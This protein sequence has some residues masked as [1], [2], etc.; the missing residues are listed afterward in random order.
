MYTVWPYTA[1]HVKV[2]AKSGASKAKFWKDGYT[3]AAG[4]FD[5]AAVSGGRDAVRAVASF[6]VL[7]VDVAGTKAAR[8]GSPGA[9]SFGAAVRLVGPVAQL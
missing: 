4:R 5:Y 3:D 1:P 8:T 6:A 7:V 9:A 2:F